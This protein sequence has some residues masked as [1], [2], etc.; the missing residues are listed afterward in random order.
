MS[1]MTP[2][3]ARPAPGTRT[4]IGV[5]CGSVKPRYG[6]ASSTVPT[7]HGLVEAVR[8]GVEAGEEVALVVGDGLDASRPRP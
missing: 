8:I 6:A 5:V 2:K 7:V 4:S 3:R 1:E